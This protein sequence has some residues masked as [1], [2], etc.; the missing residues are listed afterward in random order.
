MFLRFDFIELTS[1]L[2]IA[3][4]GAA[5]GSNLFKRL[6][7][8]FSRSIFRLVLINCRSISSTFFISITPFN[9]ETSYSSACHRCSFALLPY[10]LHNP[11]LTNLRVPHLLFKFGQGF[12]LLAE[13]FLPQLRDIITF[14]LPLLELGFKFPYLCSI[15]R[16]LFS[17][18][19]DC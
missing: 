2:N 15:P 12:E 9:S 17:G 1:D 16:S 8:A 7:A 5:S 4:S 19:F 10:S 13:P 11:G 14:G 18:F 6:S 3:C